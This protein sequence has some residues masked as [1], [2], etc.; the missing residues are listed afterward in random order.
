MAETFSTPIP[1]RHVGPI[2][3]VSELL[4][5]NAHVPLATYETPL[6]PSVARGAKVSRLVGGIEV[7]LKDESMSR[8]IL[9]EA[10]SSQS[11]WAICQDL[12]H[13]KT[14]ITDQIHLSSQ[15]A[16]FK[17]FHIETVGPLIFLRLNITSGAASGHNMV[18]KAAE[19][20][21]RWMVK[22]Y[23]TLKEVSISGNYCTD[24][25]VSA[26]NGVLG[27]GK[28]VTAEI[29]IPSDICE[30]YLR[31]TPQKIVGL[32]LK[33]NMVGST[34]AGSL[35]S[36]NAHYANILLAVYLATGQDAANIIEGSQGITYAS[37]TTDH[38]LQ[39]SVNLPNII[40][41]VI[42]NGKHH[43]FIQ[44]NL[45]AMGCDPADGHQSSQKLAIITAAAVLCSELSLMAALTNPGELMHTHAV[46]ERQRPPAKK[47]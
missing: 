34:L 43:A 9:L 35:R 40:V 2:S 29:L 32:N 7:I 15:H 18:T 1:T 11:A 22:T 4:T 28:N 27:R 37:V 36:A 47:E 23:P 5:G 42:G 46:L 44:D 24:K 19:F 3:I 33:K 10:P 26:I 38:M 41:G 6:W 13:R 45:K 21:L 39:F 8:S 20:I 30:K 31:T 16:Q 14:E 12:E 25:K 17:D